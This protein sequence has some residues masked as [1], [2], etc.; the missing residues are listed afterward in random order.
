MLL[1][2]ACR[3]KCARGSRHHRYSFIY[4]HKIPRAQE[5][6]GVETAGPHR[7]TFGVGDV[8][9]GSAAVPRSRARSLFAG[10]MRRIARLMP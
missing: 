6:F 4:S 2:L 10:D 7:G 3:A 1:T 9:A 8:L 5:I